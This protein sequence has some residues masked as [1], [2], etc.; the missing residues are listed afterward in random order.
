MENDDQDS[1]MQE[2]QTG[3]YGTQEGKTERLCG[4]CHKV[5]NGKPGRRTRQMKELRGYKTSQRITVPAAHS[6]FDVQPVRR[7]I[8]EK[9]VLFAQV[10]GVY[11]WISGTCRDLNVSGNVPDLGTR[12]ISTNRKRSLLPDRST[13]TGTVTAGHGHS[14][15]QVPNFFCKTRSGS[16]R[17]IHLIPCCRRFGLFFLS[18]WT[19]VECHIFPEWPLSKNSHQFSW[20][21]DFLFQKELGKCL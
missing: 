1:C 6:R 4:D 3:P 18:F 15:T 14:C 7:A 16:G 5:W 20:S 8:Q 21:D 13:E 10:F 17:N 19:A 11:W 9:S 12:F 2:E